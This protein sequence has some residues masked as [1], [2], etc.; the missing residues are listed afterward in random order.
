A[1]L[2]ELEEDPDT[3]QEAVVGDML[4]MLQ[5]TKML[6]S[7]AKGMGAEVYAARLHEHMTPLLRYAAAW[8]PADLRH[9]VLAA[10]GDLAS[11]LGVH[12]AA[13]APQIAEAVH[14]ELSPAQ[15][16]LNKQNACHACGQLCE[17]AGPSGAPLA[18]AVAA[19]ALPLLIQSADEAPAV[20]DNACAAL[21]RI[22]HFQAAAIAAMPQHAYVTL[23]LGAF[24]LKEDM[25][26]TYAVM[27]A[28]LGILSVSIGGEGVTGT[29]EMAPLLTQIREAWKRGMDPNVYPGGAHPVVRQ[30]TQQALD[31]VMRHWVSTGD[32]TRA[33][34]LRDTLHSS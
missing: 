16:A 8:R 28:L 1:G 11:P 19:G 20:V 23:L 5:L 29:P 10:I 34:N 6:P 31:D 7:L 4:L 24:P 14:R 18:A 17:H 12:I 26:E 27:R 15:P 30:C 9:M 33:H 13:F 25:P 22:I 32:A 3:V 2:A 21:A